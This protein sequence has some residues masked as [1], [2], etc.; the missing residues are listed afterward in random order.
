M[1]PLPQRQLRL[2]LASIA[3]VLLGAATGCGSNGDDGAASGPGDDTGAQ[4]SAAEVPEGV[5]RE[6]TTMGEEIRAEGGETTQ[7]QWRIAYIV[8]PAEPWYETSDG[9]QIRRD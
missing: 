4:R 2:V 5:A 9:Q 8:E 1:P 7:G 6:Y 3:A